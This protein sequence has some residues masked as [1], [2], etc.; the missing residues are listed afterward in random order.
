MGRRYCGPGEV[1]GRGWGILWRTVTQK[2]ASGPFA[3]HELG[4][5]GLRAS[6][7]TGGTALWLLGRG[8]GKSGLS[9]EGASDFRERQSGPSFL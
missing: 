7:K 2:G 9:F 1:L 8:E 3:N 6:H 4:E 5:S